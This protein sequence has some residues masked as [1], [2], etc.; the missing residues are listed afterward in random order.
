M[1]L[2]PAIDLKGGQ[3]VRLLRGDM[4]QATVFN[5]DPAAQARAFVEQ[6]AQWLHVVDLDG[7]VAGK[8]VNETAVRAILGAVSVPVQL[9]GGIRDIA[10]I[11]TW[12]DSG[13][14]RVILGTAAVT[15][16]KLVDGA[17]DQFPGRIA[18]GIDARDGMVAVKGW[19]ET[20]TMTAVELAGRFKGVGVAT[21]IFTDIDR[22]G[23]MRGVNVTATAAL[24]AAVDIPVIASG[25]VSKLDEIRALKK[26]EHR[27]VEGA[28]IGRALYERKFTLREALDAARD[29]T[30]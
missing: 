23:A 8:A 4:D 5:T 26:H 25:G 20:G 1:I 9:G 15:N 14:K 11:A 2:Y 30:P 29:E 13:V 12:L 3:C 7:A 27:G 22:D 19:T 18:V 6:G 21:I 24:A 28:I 16:P 17:C 10:S